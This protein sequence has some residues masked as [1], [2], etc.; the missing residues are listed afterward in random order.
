M[1]SAKRILS[2]LKN[3][4]VLIFIIGP[5]VLLLIAFAFY[6]RRPVYFFNNGH[7]GS[8]VSYTYSDSSHNGNSVCKKIEGKSFTGFKYTLKPGVQYP[9]SGI[10][11]QPKNKKFIDLSDYDYIKVKLKASQGR[12]LPFIISTYIENYT[13]ME[14]YETFRYNQFILNA[15]ST[16]KEIKID[17]SQLKTPD[18]WYTQNNKSEA[19]LT[20]P[21]YSKVLQ[22]NIANC[23]ALPLNKEDM[24]EVHKLTVNRN[25]APFFRYAVPLLLI[26]YVAGTALITVRKRKKNSA[27]EINFSYEK[28]EAISYQSREENIIFQYITTNYTKPELTIVEVRNATGIYEQKISAIIRKRAG[29]NFKQFLNKLRVTEAKR[30]L[31]ETDLPVSEI[32]FKV[33]YGNVSHFN[34]VFKEQEGCSPNE[35]RK[36]RVQNK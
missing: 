26:Y 35:K 1:I 29:V 16:L 33:G 7:S 24:V 32:A 20:E 8:F 19:E 23:I 25:L 10:V 27:A 11:F 18:W 12:R 6:Y 31:H 36:S 14:K 28:T 22:I 21:N 9:F 15:D 30:L 5:I 17:F 3:Y 2:I 34:R 4:T 13:Q